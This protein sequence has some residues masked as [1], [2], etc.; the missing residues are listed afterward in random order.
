MRLVVPS[1][2]GRRRRNSYNR[3]WIYSNLITGALVL[4]FAGGA[5]SSVSAEFNA[6]QVEY[7]GHRSTCDRHTIM[8]EYKR[9]CLLEELDSALNAVG[10]QR[11]RNV[12]FIRWC[13]VEFADSI[14][15]IEAIEL[16]RAMPAFVEDVQPNYAGGIA[17]EM[18]SEPYWDSLWHLHPVFQDSVA[19]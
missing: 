9:S 6:T 2:T 5:I 8:L 19:G 14:S 1:T 11:A 4:V 10:L 17:S 12:P 15:V 13:T 7:R 18:S 3:T 16:A